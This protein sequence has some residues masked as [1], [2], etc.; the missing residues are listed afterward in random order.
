VL[1]K[2]KRVE[3]IGAFPAKKEEKLAQKALSHQYG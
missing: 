2:G 3:H 1:K